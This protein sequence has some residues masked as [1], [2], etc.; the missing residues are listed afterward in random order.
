MDIEQLLIFTLLFGSTV[1]LAWP[2]GKYMR[3]VFSDEPPSVRIFSSIENRIFKFVRI[4]P[5]Q[6]MSLGQYLRA[7]LTLN[8][9]WVVYGFTLLLFQ[10]NLPFNPDGNPS[11]EWPLA[12]HSAIS[13]ITSTN[14]QHYSGE[15]GATYFS[16]IAVFSLLQFVS[17]AASLAVGVAVVRSLTSQNARLGNFYA[18][19]VRSATRILLPLCLIVSVL[20]LMRGMPM[21]FSGAESLQT[22]QG[23]TIKVSTGPVASMIPIKELGSNGGGFF[24][25]NDAHPFENP[26]AVTYIVHYII[27]LL[28]PVAF[29]FF[30][31]FYLGNRRFAWM[32]FS[33]MSAGFVFV[34]VP[35]IFQELTGNSAVAAMGIDISGGNMEGKETRFGTFL[36]ALYAG[37]NA[38]VPAGTIT[39]MHDSFMPLSGLLMMAGMQID[40]FFGGL[41]TGWINMFLY[42][43][44]AVFLGS[45][46]IGRTP[47]LFGR[48]IGIS[49]VQLA[50][51]ASVLQ[52][53]IPMSLTAVASY[54][55]SVHG[56]G[57]GWLS[58][59][60]AHGLSTMHYEFVSASAGNGSGFEGLGDN[61]PFWNLSTSIAMLTGRFVPIIAALCIGWRISQK[62]AVEASAGTL[63]TES[64][65]F[66]IFL[67]LTIIILNALCSFPIFSLGP[68]SE[69]FAL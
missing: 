6:A 42:M 18:D 54:L 7:F 61:T 50:V 56:D 49:E 69:Y 27:V 32:V 12:L 29:L 51:I 25:T 58:N 11:M 21:T 57:L 55:Y 67:F 53:A 14:L 60:G 26:D 28:L 37:E 17:A 24:G 36:S 4:D 45:L 23:D 16:Q 20:F 39:A 9:L 59:T 52:L 2:L 64:A 15:T 33:V 19:F 62:K 65:T 1:L 31:G 40:A 30:T 13:F 68:L 5:N 38:C 47:E 3:W 63:R 35:I 41:G 34:S 46:M 10:G 8:L 66:G 48:K 43:I 44:V 22:L